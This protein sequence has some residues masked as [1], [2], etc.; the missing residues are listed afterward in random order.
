MKRKS[1]SLIVL[2]LAA[3]G[4]CGLRYWNLTAGVDAQGLPRTGHLSAYLMAGW[5][6]LCLAVFIVL[7]RTSQGRSRAHSVM[8]TGRRL[9]VLGYLGAALVLLSGIL[10]FADALLA[11]PGISSPILCLMSL[12]AGGCL[13]AVA[14]MRS[15]SRAAYPP[16]ELLPEVYLVVKLIL[17][18][19]S[20]SVDPVILDYCVML[21]AMLFVVLGFYFSTGFLFEQGR[22]RLMLLCAMG[23]CMFSAM[24]V[25]DGVVDGSTATVVE[26]LGYIAWLIPVLLCAATPTQDA[27]AQITEK[28]D[29]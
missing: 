17:S 26:Y 6:M 22:P 25:A 29:K 8:F 18:F 23:A 3:L 5:C 11:G 19:K 20:W 15:H 13:F 7:A 1:V 9:A 16:L 10:D 12:F 4:G 24:A 14:W 2:L 28:Q 21:F 27:A